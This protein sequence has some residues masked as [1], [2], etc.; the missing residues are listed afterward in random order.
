MAFLPLRR[1]CFTALALNLSRPTASAISASVMPSSLMIAGQL[2]SMSGAYS[3]ADFCP[4][5]K[6]KRSTLPLNDAAM[7]HMKGDIGKRVRRLRKAKGLTQKE[8]GKLAG[9][10]GSAIK[11]LE[12]GRSESSPALHKIA[13]AL[14]STPEEL[15]TGRPGR[16][17]PAG[18]F[19]AALMEHLITQL[20]L[21]L[22]AADAEIPPADKGKRLVEVYTHYAGTGERPGRAVILSLVRRAA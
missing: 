15:E 5:V 7:H 6:P 3:S 17:Q 10:S 21:A 4:R 14:D 11:E 9:V 12:R 2:V 8:L 22:D 1:S 18:A 16:A 20:E 19:D 13:A